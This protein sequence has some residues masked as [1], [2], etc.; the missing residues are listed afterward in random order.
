MGFFDCLPA[1]G[2]WQCKSKIDV[3]AFTPLPYCP[4]NTLGWEKVPLV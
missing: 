1:S 4:T 3:S 2:D